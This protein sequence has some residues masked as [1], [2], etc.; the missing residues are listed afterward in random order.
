MDTSRP[1][2]T[3]FHAAAALGV[4]TAGV[5]AL[6][7]ARSDVLYLPGLNAALRAGFLI[8]AFATAVAARSRRPTSPMGVLVLG[9]GFVFA[10]TT[11]QAF[12]EPLLYG[13]GRLVLPVCT[14][15][16]LYAFLAFPSGR[17]ADRASRRAI[18]FTAVAMGGAWLFTALVTDPL[19]SAGLLSR[20]ADACPDNPFAV[21]GASAGLADAAATVV[22][23]AQA[24]AAIAITGAL[25]VRLRGATP[26]ERVTL[27]AALVPLVA[28]AIGYALT[29]V[30]QL[31]GADG[32]AN[33]VSWVFTPLLALIAIAVL[34]GQLRGRMFAGAALREMLSQLGPHPNPEAMERQMAAAF[35]DPSLRIAYR[36][37]GGG[38][39][40]SAGEPL[41]VP[42]GPASGVGEVWDG[43]ERVAV[44][45][46]D[47]PL[48]D[49]PGFVEAA[50]AA[51]VLAVRNARLSA[52]LRSSVRALHA[53][54]ARISA[55]VDGARRDLE[56]H[57]ALGPQ[58]ELERVR[59]R[60]AEAAAGQ[61][62]P[63][64]RELLAGL[65]EATDLAAETLDEAAHGIYPRR[66]VEDGLVAALEAQL[67]A[68]GAISTDGPVRRGL[69][70]SEAA[71]FFACMEAAQNA[72]KHAGERSDVVV[73][74]REDD[75]RLRFVVR[76]DGDGFD[77]QAARR[78]RGLA[79][80]RDR[81]EAVGGHVSIVS[82]PGRGTTVMGDVP[83]TDQREVR[84]QGT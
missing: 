36:S 25:L 47:H 21:S 8:V 82:I 20:C 13:I 31:A 3:S 63:A 23:G 76:D 50:G 27:D 74:L 10:I 51:T 16:L 30:L 19:P 24:A 11:L 9:I 26:V 58:L 56:R 75:G 12:P 64:R 48:D 68:A 78:S 2:A 15:L 43:G 7:V 80:I 4:A 79:N 45:L 14:V 5:S 22:A 77:A 42:D 62:D 41:D 1:D 70:E 44:I 59:A 81:V 66:L 40:D 72:L 37:A 55:A 33:D 34:V 69:D 67:G 39:L 54:R 53:S 6:L 84:G 52:E 18:G 46:S 57:L 61:T 28:L 60:L 35:G 83:W 17:I 29:F 73:T 38:Y 49:V 71:A 32:A 65:G